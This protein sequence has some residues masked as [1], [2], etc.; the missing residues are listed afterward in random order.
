MTRTSRFSAGVLLLLLLLATVPPSYAST[1]PVRTGDRVTY[2]Y[3]Q[4]LL[5]PLPN[6]TTYRQAYVSKFSIDILS[7]ATSS[8]PGVIGYT[9]SY[10]SYQNATVTQTAVTGGVNSTFIFDPYDNQ[11]YLG[12][13]GFYPFIYTDVASG[14]MKGLVVHQSITQGPSG[15]ISGRNQINVTVTRPNSF[16]DVNFTA[17]S[18]T[19]TS[20]STTFLRFNATSGVLVYGIT[21]VNLLSLERDFIFQLDAYVQGPAPSI[22]VLAYVIL[23]SFVAV[24]VLALLDR[25]G[26]FN[27]RGR[28][29]RKEWKGR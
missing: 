21:K 12:E 19:S 10:E 28:V 6:G 11:T 23:G 22:P 26:V 5:E 15:T 1:T 20:P 2:N 14:S 16:I 18:G 27:R 4:A 8:V 3:S 25:A 7:V 24:V 13:L 17:K 9:L 29:K